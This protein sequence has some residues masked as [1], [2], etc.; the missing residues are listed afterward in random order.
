MGPCCRDSRGPSVVR[1]LTTLNVLPRRAF[2]EFAGIRWVKAPSVQHQQTVQR[3]FVVGAFLEVAFPL[4]ARVP[5]SKRP[6]VLVQAWW[7]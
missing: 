2:V 4:T 1:S 6:Q 7:T 3:I 5:V